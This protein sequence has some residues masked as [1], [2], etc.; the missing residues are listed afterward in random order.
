MSDQTLAFGE[1]EHRTV[2]QYR[3]YQ[4]QADG[5]Y[6]GNASCQAA[7]HR[8]IDEPLAHAAGVKLQNLS[9]IGE[10]AAVYQR[11]RKALKSPHF[12]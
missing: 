8:Q 11:K 1:I 4:Q 6:E 3:A 2:D 5:Y 9:P 12:A 7:Q 10:L